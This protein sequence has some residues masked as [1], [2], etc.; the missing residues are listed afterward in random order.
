MPPPPYFRK[1]DLVRHQ[2]LA[3]FK[4]SSQQKRSQ[5]VDATMLE[6]QLGC[7]IVR[8]MIWVASAAHREAQ[9]EAESDLQ[10]TP[11]I[12]K[13][14]MIDALRALN[15]SSKKNTKKRAE[16]A[17]LESN[18]R[19]CANLQAFEDRDT[20]SCS[21][22]PKK[23]FRRIMKHVSALLIAHPQNRWYFSYAHMDWRARAM[24]QSITEDL[25]HHMLQNALRLAAVRKP[26]HSD[27]L[28]DAD[29]VNA[30]KMFTK[31]FPL[32]RCHVTPLSNSWWFAPAVTPAAPANGE[33]N[34]QQPAQQQQQ[35][36]HNDNA[37]YIDNGTN[38]NQQQQDNNYG[39][40]GQNQQHQNHINNGE[41]QNRI[42]NQN[43][44]PSPS[45]SP[46][47]RRDS[48]HRDNNGDQERPQRQ[49]RATAGI[50]R[51]LNAVYQTNVSKM[52]DV[53]DVTNRR[54]ATT[55]TYPTSMY[56]AVLRSLRES[57]LLRRIPS[58]TVRS[59]DN[60]L[61]LKLRQMAADQ[62]T[63]TIGQPQQPN[64]RRSQRERNQGLMTLADLLKQQGVTTQAQLD[65]MV[66]NILN[67]S[68]G[69]I[70]ELR[71]LAEA[72]N[73]R[74]ILSRTGPGIRKVK[75]EV[76][77]PN[78]QDVIYVNQH[79]VEYRWYGLRPPT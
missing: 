68:D 59:A 50:N 64:R 10:G 22:H 75:D 12:K 43:P 31:F 60:Q 38:H 53:T 40:D 25:T 77:N 30:M 15:L 42:Q 18:P 20:T 56:H 13:K 37:N 26:G 61:V 7:S 47:Q 49:R 4:S 66:A 17:S 74:I 51:R 21:M 57:R 55:S 2:H 39:D 73:L 54:L 16:T 52:H 8:W 23:T 48:R 5:H 34:Q 78:G 67:N 28:Y 72:L 35:N 9:R 65:A 62:I 63:I 14:H 45:P 76:V 36:I 27:R 3:G 6:E 71:A 70:L 44:H 79:V 29:V 41:Q 46:R 32:P 24:L 19:M 58:S 11:K 33:G 1:T 69:N